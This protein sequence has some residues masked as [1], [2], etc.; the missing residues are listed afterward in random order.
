MPRSEKGN[1]KSDN[2][3]PLRDKNTRINMP[4]T[5]WRERKG[6]IAGSDREGTDVIM[7]GLRRFYHHNGFDP[8]AAGNSVKAFPRDLE[9]WE[10]KEVR[11]GNIS[12][13]GGRAGRRALDH[14]ARRAIRKK[15]LKSIEN[16]KKRQ[17]AKNGDGAW[18][19][20]HDDGDTESESSNHGPTKR[21][22]RGQEVDPGLAA[23]DQSYIGQQA[24]PTIE[25][26][27]NG[28][29]NRPNFVQQQGGYAQAMGHS[30]VQYSAYGPSTFPTPAP[31]RTQQ[32]PYGGVDIQATRD[33]YVHTQAPAP[34][35]NSI[36]NSHFYPEDRYPRFNTGVQNFGPQVPQQTSRFAGQHPTMPTGVHR[37]GPIDSP[38]SVPTPARNTLAAGGQRIQ[39][40]SQQV[41]GKRRQRDTPDFGAEDAGTTNP[42][43]RVPAAPNSGSMNLNPA[44]K[45]QRQNPPPVTEPTQQR[46]HHPSRTPRPSRY[47]VGGAPRPLLPLDPIFGGAQSGSNPLGNADGGFTSPATISRELDDLFRDSNPTPTPNV[48]VD[49]SNDAPRRHE[50]RQVLGKHRREGPT[51]DEDIDIRDMRPA[52]RDESQSLDSALRYT[53]DAF[54]AWTGREA[55]VT[56]LE[57]SYNFQY[58]EI[59]SAFRA[60]WRS[61]TNPQRGDPL[62][63]LWRARR[64]SGTIDDWDAPEDGEHLPEVRRG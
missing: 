46:H 28:Y 27:Q 16:G 2:L 33:P 31:R 39:Q 29:G 36:L 53:R 47:G 7:D 35:D 11:L 45:R 38:Y 56:N 14:E 9:P 48:N 42:G 4:M 19:R 25:H 20:S 58:R 12:Q 57:H 6:T 62:P 50:P 15:F 22:R 30:R 64:W 43:W 61:E 1:D 44:Y 24:V 54:R 51:W 55:P 59:R 23:F 18:K 37:Q 17:A 63:E 34:L 8:V 41:L 3:V 60:W 13:F 40:A 21:R 52:N 10:V 5:R 32:H 26:G 49:Q